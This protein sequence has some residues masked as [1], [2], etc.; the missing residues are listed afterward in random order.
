[1]LTMLHFANMPKKFWDYA[2]LTAATLY[3][4][5]MTRILHEIS[6]MEAIFGHAPDYDKLRTFGCKCYPCLRHHWRNKLDDKSISCVFI[7]N[8]IYVSKNVKFLE[9]DFTLNEHL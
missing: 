6:P 3:N 4:K 7:E 2:I 9:K 5:N 1:M 8:K